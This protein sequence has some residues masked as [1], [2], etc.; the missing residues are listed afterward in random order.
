MSPAAVMK[1]YK[2]RH[3]TTYR[4]D[5]LASICHNEVRL[6][7]L[8]MPTQRCVS[9]EFTVT[10]TP[11]TTDQFR[12]FFG[13]MVTSFSIQEPHDQLEI[14]FNSLFE[15]SPPLWLGVDEDPIA[16]DLAAEQLRSQTG[17][18]AADVRQFALASPLIAP[19]ADLRDY[20]A[21]SFTKGKPLCQAALDLM[22]RIYHDFEFVSGFT[23]ISTPL[24][25]LL[26]HRR[27]VCQDFAQLAIGCLRSLGLPA[28]YV[29]GYIETAPPPGQKRLI[30]ADASHAW[31]SAYHPRAGWQDF[32]P[33]N[34]KQPNGQHITL[35]YGRDFS[36]ISPVKGVMVGSGGHE[37]DVAVDVIPSNE[38][39]S[40]SQFQQQS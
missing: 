19:A 18:K 7:P 11:A 31:F 37:I 5:G 21:P 25:E 39:H 32:D 17:A 12:D 14:E 6:T 26:Q 40:Q 4:Y 2:V 24:S 29:S 33:T 36:D 3:N 1:V 35:S 27:G 23:T 22:R 10:P 30:G 20:A 38:F 34:N 16:W 13:N 15:V 9:T 28:R 8:T